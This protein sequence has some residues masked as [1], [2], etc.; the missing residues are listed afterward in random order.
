MQI[1]FTAKF[2][3]AAVLFVLLVLDLGLV[4]VCRKKFE[5]LLKTPLFWVVSLVTVCLLVV[6]L[7]M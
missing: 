3:I 7:R 6:C 5:T 1:V 4:I 2:I